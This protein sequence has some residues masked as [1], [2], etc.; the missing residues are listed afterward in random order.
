[1]A[2]FTCLQLAEKCFHPVQIG[3]TRDFN[4]K[5]A[6]KMLRK[7]I[8]WRKE[9]QLDSFLTD[10]KPPEVLKKYFCYNFLC[11]DKEGGVVRYLDYGQTDIAGL[12]NSAKKIDVFKYV[13]LCL[14]R[15]FE[16]LKQHNKKIGKLA[17]QITYIDNFS[18][19]TFANA[20]HMKN[21]ETLLY[22]IKIY[23]D[24]YPE[25]IKRVIIING[26]LCLM[27]I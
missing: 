6:E 16:A 18:N 1:M 19:L 11:F 15:D 13:V 26:K 21:I 14:E 24:N 17:Y 20:T 4:L 8:I 25:R 10:Y 7:H 2:K 23:L 27:Y 9:M 3:L 5:E 22:Y 12:W